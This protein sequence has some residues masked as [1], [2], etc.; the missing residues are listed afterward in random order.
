MGL[1]RVAANIRKSRNITENHRKIPQIAEI[2]GTELSRIDHVAQ[3]INR[4]STDSLHSL[5]RLVRHK[6]VS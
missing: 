1:K 4:P 5:L 3:A 6:Y 2:T